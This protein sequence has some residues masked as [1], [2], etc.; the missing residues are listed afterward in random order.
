MSGGGFA[1]GGPRLFALPVILGG[2]KPVFPEGRVERTPDRAR[3]P[4][5]VLGQGGGMDGPRAVA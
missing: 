1:H 4:G 5:P 2:G 3:S